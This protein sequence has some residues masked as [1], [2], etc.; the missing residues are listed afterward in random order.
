MSE[1]A[2]M[3]A[4][5]GTKGIQMLGQNAAL[6]AQQRARDRKVQ[7]E[8]EELARQQKRADEIAAE[9]KS[10]IAREF[11]IALGTLIAAGADG[12]VTSAALARAGAASGAVA[13]LDKARIESN[14]QEGQSARRAD[15]IALIEEN[16]AAAATTK[17]AIANNTLNF[18]GNAV[19][20]LMESDYSFSATDVTSRGPSMGSYGRFGTKN[21][22]RK[23]GFDSSILGKPGVGP[24]GK[25]TYPDTRPFML[26][27]R[28]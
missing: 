9:D 25:T 23:T 21:P 5:I 2:M 16:Q 7:R 19:G 26:R 15:S 3:A 18:F 11:D 20:T 24:Y 28:N 27:P 12:G 14:R 17:M 8:V 10:D 22:P 6:K 1:M 13:G 4:S